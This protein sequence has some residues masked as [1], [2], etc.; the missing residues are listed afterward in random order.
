[1]CMYKN[2]YKVVCVYLYW[3]IFTV[4]FETVVYETV[5]Y[6]RTLQNCQNAKKCSS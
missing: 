2:L 1:M 4:L 3:D 5:V 6:E